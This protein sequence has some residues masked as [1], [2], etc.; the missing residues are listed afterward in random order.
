MIMRSTLSTN[1]VEKHRC[2]QLSNTKANGAL[3]SQHAS[4]GS[5]SWPFTTYFLIS[6]IA[7]FVAVSVFI[8]GR[9]FY[10]WKEER[11][12]GAWFM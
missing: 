5:V 2:Q 11:D 8:A 9:W 1:L 4:V 3:S 12:V 7:F 6:F 10:N